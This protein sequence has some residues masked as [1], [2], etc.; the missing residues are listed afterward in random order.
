ME[1]T[2][3]VALVTGGCSGLGLATAK[4]LAAL[5]ASVVMVDLATAAAREAAAAAGPR[6]S[7]VPADVLDERQMTDAL[8]AAEAI[9]PIRIVVHCAGR[10]GPHPILNERGEPAPLEPL[11]RLVR[12]NLIGSVNVLRLVAARMTKY[13]PVAP[14]AERGVFVFTASTAAEEGKP[15]QIPYSASKAG[16]IGLTLPA[17]RELGPYG[18]RVCSVAPGTFD[19]P[20]LENRFSA[21]EMERR[22]AVKPF[23]RR[24]GHPGEF[25]QL[26]AH[27]IGNPMINGTTL[28]LDGADR[29]WTPAS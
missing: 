3:R 23:P 14:D 10:G 25:A 19:T 27:V 6:T 11:E 1:I 12:L 5:G 21:T 28:R 2:N 16:V 13:E 4:H 29:G 20:L 9:G 22:M 18:I 7:Y 17:A 8:D 24:L 26:A 15:G